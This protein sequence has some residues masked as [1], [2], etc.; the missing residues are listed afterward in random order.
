MEEKDGQ[1]NRCSAGRLPACGASTSLGHTL[2]RQSDA[3][4][5]LVRIV[6]WPELPIG[7]IG[8]YVSPEIY[9]DVLRAEHEAAQTYLTRIQSELSALEL[10]TSIAI[11]TGLAAESILDI[12]DELGA[13]A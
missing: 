13:R 4:L 11:R 8:G 1:D 12:A 6:P 2:A 5:T 7:D 9:D 10:S 3:S